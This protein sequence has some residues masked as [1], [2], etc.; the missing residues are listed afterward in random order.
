MPSNTD[1][2]AE[3][4]LIHCTNAAE[5]TDADDEDGFLECLVAYERLPEAGEHLSELDLA[6]D[7]EKAALL[8]KLKSLRDLR[9]T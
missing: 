4:F 3:A 5:A 9:P 1:T 7:S 6:D 2:L 8:A